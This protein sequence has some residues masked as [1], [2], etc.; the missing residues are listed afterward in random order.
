MTF[1][2]LY[3]GKDAGYGG[4]HVL[5]QTL[6][7]SERALAQLPEDAHQLYEGGIGMLLRAGVSP[8]AARRV[9]AGLELGRK[10]LQPL[11]VGIPV[12]DADG[13]AAWLRPRLLGLAHEELHMLCLSQRGTVIDLM[14]L[15]S[16]AK[17]ATIVDCRQILGR[18]LTTGCASFVLAHNHPSGDP[19]PS[20]ED[21][22]ATYR[23]SAG[24]KLL[25]LR[26]MDH[27]IFGAAGCFVSMNERGCV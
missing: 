14:P 25:G 3:E 26:L 2:L 24:A 27:L 8:V 4:V 13:A 11:P 20:D 15:T 21:K 6:G 19:T 12:R 22:E 23:V 10:S 18:A 5:L 17:S 9:L 16:G 1:G 7:V